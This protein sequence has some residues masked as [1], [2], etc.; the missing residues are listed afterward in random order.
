MSCEKH[1]LVR[2]HTVYA[3]PALGA[4]MLDAVGETQRVDGRPFRAE[5]LRHGARSSRAA[6]PPARYTG[7]AFTM[8]YRHFALRKRHINRSASYRWLFVQGYTESWARCRNVMRQRSHDS[9]PPGPSSM[10]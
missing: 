9:D 7:D 10:T 5:A 3:D 8:G 2:T 6:R 4:A 1:R